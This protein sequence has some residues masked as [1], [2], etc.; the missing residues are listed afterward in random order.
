MSYWFSFPKKVFDDNMSEIESSYLK[1]Y[2]NQDEL[3]EEI[4]LNSHIDFD[5][6]TLFGSGNDS[7]TD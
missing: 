1:E 4:N 5:A 3:M 2:Q 6:S 7:N